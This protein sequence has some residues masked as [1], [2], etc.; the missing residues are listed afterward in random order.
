[1]LWSPAHVNSWVMYTLQHFNLPL[2]PAEYFNMDGAA[3]IALTEEEFNQRAPQVRL[4]PIIK[5]GYDYKKRL[6]F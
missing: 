4:F 6:I 3:L 2:V 5:C 1:M